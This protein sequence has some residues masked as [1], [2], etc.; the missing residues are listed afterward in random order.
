VRG[1]L[2]FVERLPAAFTPFVL[3]IAVAIAGR[4][5]HDALYHAV[6]VGTLRLPAILVI[7]GRVMIGNGPLVFFASRLAAFKHRSRVAVEAPL[8]DHGRLFERRWIR[9]E[10]VE[11]PHVLEALEIGP[12]ADT[13]GLYEVVRRMRIVPVSRV[14]TLPIALAVALPLIGVF[15]TQMPLKDALLK[16]LAPLMGM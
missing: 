6:P 12:V 2:G 1:G 10:S 3:G 9:H 4:W 16:V 11:D 13:V 5:A 15:A 14:S 7:A 8:A